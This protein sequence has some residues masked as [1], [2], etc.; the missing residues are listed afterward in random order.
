MHQVRFSF[1][2]GRATVEIDGTATTA[3]GRTDILVHAYGKPL[4]V[5]ELK[6]QGLELT[7]DDEAQGLSYAKVMTPPFPL[8][9]VT[10]GGETRILAAHSGEA[11]QPATPSEEE[12]SKLVAAAG[13]AAMGDLKQAVSALMGSN[14]A[15][16]VQAVRAAS[17][18]PGNCSTQRAPISM[19]GV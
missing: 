15:V 12:F 9:V 13:R 4:A 2:I 14:P 19:L 8:V 11:W 17:N 16:W 3:E 7:P 10:N 6:R 5:F 18:D 1:T